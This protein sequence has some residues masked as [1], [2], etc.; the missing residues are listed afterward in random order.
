MVDVLT[1]FEGVALNF[2]T[3]WTI[4]I[5]VVMCAH[6]E[7]IQSVGCQASD[8]H[9]LAR[10]ANTINGMMLKSAPNTEHASY[11]MLHHCQQHVHSPSDSVLLFLNTNI[12]TLP[13]QPLSGL[14]VLQN[15]Q[16]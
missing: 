12:I 11:H 3:V 10:A 4:L 9:T 5:V 15:Q 7:F 2:L 13:S 1:I 16:I 8:L 14:P 6:F